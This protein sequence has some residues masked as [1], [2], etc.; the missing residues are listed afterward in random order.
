M[1]VFVLIGLNLLIF[2]LAF[3]WIMVPAFYGLPSKPTKLERI[4]KAFLIIDL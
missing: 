3:L 1:I 4:R 2:T